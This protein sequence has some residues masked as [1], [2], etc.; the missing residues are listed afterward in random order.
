MIS[1]KLV[2]L[3]LI[4]FA[5]LSFAFIYVPG[6]SFAITPCGSQAS[7]TQYKPAI[8]IGCQG[9]G[10]AIGDMLFA[11]V[12]FLS[13]G[14][15]LVVIGSIIV[16]GISYITSEGNPQQTAK[17]VTRIKSAIIALFLYIFAYAILNYLVPGMV[18]H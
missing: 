7:G 9:K 13:D 11:F 18:L 5:M 14:V 1:H 4:I 12:R 3:T 17:A 16:G 6:S 8:D 10:N 15:G 2:S